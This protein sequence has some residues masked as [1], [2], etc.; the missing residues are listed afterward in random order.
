MGECPPPL[1]ELVA[2]QEG[3]THP[4]LTGTQVGP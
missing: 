3:L 4:Q 2:Q 1:E